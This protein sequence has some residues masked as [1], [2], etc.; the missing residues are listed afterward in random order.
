[1]D[2]GAA[3]EHVEAAGLERLTEGLGV[4]DRLVLPLAERLALGDPQADGLGRDRVLEWPALLTREDGL[5]DHRGVLF[6]AEDEPRAGPAERLVRRGRDH[7]RIRHG[8]GMLTGRD[9]AREVRHV[10]H[11]HSADVVGDLTERR[12]VEMARI[13]G[14]AGDDQLRLVLTGELGDV[15]HV[16]AVV[17]APHLVADDLVELPRDVQAHP[18]RQV[19]AVGELH[20]QD[21][22]AGIEERHVDGVVRLRAGVGLDVRV[23]GAEEGLG[24]VDREL[25]GDVDPLAAAV[26]ALAGQPLRVLVREH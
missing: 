5:V 16:D 18:V 24:P 3:G 11:Q 19:A 26:V 21:R 10:D 12:E 23:L 4:R 2:V 17:G 8:A 13:G 25:L 22:V 1:V 7:V 6:L 14:P 15:V 20:A 9:Q